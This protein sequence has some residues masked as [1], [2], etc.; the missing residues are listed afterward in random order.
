[1]KKL[2]YAAVLA[3]GL[4]VTMSA[5]APWPPSCFPNCDTTTLGK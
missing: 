2:I 4:M 1:L 3:L 5:D